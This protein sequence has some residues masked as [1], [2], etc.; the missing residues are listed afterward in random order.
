MKFDWNSEYFTLDSPRSRV[1]KEAFVTLAQRGLIYRAKRLVNWCCALESAISDMEVTHLSIDR[2]TWYDGPSGKTQVGVFH[3]FTYPVVEEN[4]ASIT[5]ATTRIETMLGDTAIAVHPTDPRYRSLIGKTI[6]HPL[7]GSRLPIIADSSVDPSFG[8]G[9]VKITPA[10][11]PLDYEIGQRHSLPLINLLDD[12]GCFTHACGV[13]EM[14]GKN[15]FHVREWIIRQLQASGNYQGSTP[16]PMRLAVCSRTGDLIEPRVVPQWY[17]KCG[18]MAQR[19]LKA[20][21]CGTLTFC[22]SADQ[23]EFCSWLEKMNDWCVSRQLWWGHRIPAYRNPSTGTWRIDHAALPDEVQDEDVLDTWF[24][25]ALLP[26][27]ATNPEYSLDTKQP[28]VGSS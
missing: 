2:P 19:V 22:D 12:R 25:S 17:I 3:Q 10:H 24:S 1:V 26:I 21:E 13:P 6:L 16:H 14:V 9:A 8:T 20:V 7:L 5:V 18:P 28:L 11:D 27:S 15:R 4:G 23:K